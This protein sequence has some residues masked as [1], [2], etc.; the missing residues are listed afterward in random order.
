MMEYKMLHTCIGVADL[1]KSLKFYTE[2]MGFKE[3]RRKN[4]PH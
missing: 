1:D 4:R 3:T 2:A